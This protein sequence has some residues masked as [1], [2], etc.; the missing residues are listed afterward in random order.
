MI[1]I[2]FL[3]V[4]HHAVI[5]AKDKKQILP[6]A[7]VTLLSAV[8]LLPTIAIIVSVRGNYRVGFYIRFTCLYTGG[9]ENTGWCNYFSLFMVLTLYAQLM[10]KYK[11]YCLL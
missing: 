5:I 2:T 8:L 7:V 9:R 11:R 1:N 6:A 10:D 3:S 4:K